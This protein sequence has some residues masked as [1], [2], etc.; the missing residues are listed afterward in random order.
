MNITI[1]VLSI[2]N[3]L[4]KIDVE[5]SCYYALPIQ[6]EKTKKQQHN[7]KKQIGRIGHEVVVM[8]CRR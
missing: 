4:M 7:N 3:V 5:E 1:V 8:S 6:D 2:A